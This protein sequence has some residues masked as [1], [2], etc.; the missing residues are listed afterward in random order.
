[1]QFSFSLFLIATKAV[2]C[3]PLPSPQP[4]LLNLFQECMSSACAEEGGVALRAS[5]DSVK[6]LNQAKTGP[7]VL[8]AVKQANNEIAEHRSTVLRLLNSVPSESDKSYKLNQMFDNRVFDARVESARQRAE[9]TDRHLSAISDRL[10][11]IHDALQFNEERIRSAR[12]VD[13]WFRKNAQSRSGQVASGIASPPAA[14][15]PDFVD[16]LTKLTPAAF[17]LKA[18]VFAAKHPDVVEYFSKRVALNEAKAAKA[19]AKA[20]K[21]AKST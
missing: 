8:D 19:A 13:Q 21:N 11:D 17:R 15:N 12:M 16:Q 7:E 2:I 10:D 3:L 9:K 5:V 20:A 14:T 4:G 18:Q 6:A 1:M